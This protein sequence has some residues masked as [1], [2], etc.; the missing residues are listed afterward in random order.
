MLSTVSSGLCSMCTVLVDK[1]LEFLIECF[2]YFGKIIDLQVVAI[3]WLLSTDDGGL[4]C[5]IKALRL[6]P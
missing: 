4:K 1:T 6:H 5:A 3:S 2:K